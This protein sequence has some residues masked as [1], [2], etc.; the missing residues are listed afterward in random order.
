MLAAPSTTGAAAGHTVFR[1]GNCIGVIAE[2]VVPLLILPVLW[3]VV[4]F[5]YG[6]RYLRE[7][8][9]QRPVAA[10][11]RRTSRSRP[12]NVRY[13]FGAYEPYKDGN[14]WEAVDSLEKDISYLPLADPRREP[15][16][17]HAYADHGYSDGRV[18]APTRVVYD[19]GYEDV[20]GYDSYGEDPE[21][22]GAY[23]D[24]YR[25]DLA[26]V[27]EL[28]RVAVTA[29]APPNLRASRANARVA[30]RRRRQIFFSLVLAFLASLGTAAWSGAMM[31]WGVHGVAVML[32]AGYVS[33]LVHHHQRTVE[34]STKVHHLPAPARR[35]ARRPAAV[36]LNGGT[37]P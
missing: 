34:R 5:P 23:G 18:H 3:A 6:V 8:R 16:R 29:A 37:A 10:F 14:G 17:Q 27:Q 19:D 12:S 9:A 36:V 33:L 22:V 35:P 30:L 4:L 7:R 28:P 32:L 21:E 26:E 20:E 13:V 31:A 15:R 1:S 25:D 2:L 24:A 11:S